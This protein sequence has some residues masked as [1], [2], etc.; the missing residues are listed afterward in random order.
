MDLTNDPIKIVSR[1]LFDDSCV[2]SLDPVRDNYMPIDPKLIRYGD[3]T[4]NG[5]QFDQVLSSVQKSIRRG[6]FGD[7]FQFGLEL[8]R[9]GDLYRKI[10]WNRLFV[11]SVEDIGP[12]NPLIVVELYAL[13]KIDT[14]LSLITAIYLFCKS[15]KSRLN[16]NAICAFFRD[17]EEYRNKEKLFIEAIQYKNIYK[18]F[19]VL[20]EVSGKDLLW[21]QVVSNM[22]TALL[23][24]L[25]STKSM[26]GSGGSKLV[27]AHIIHLH[28]MNM[29][30]T[31]E[32]YLVAINTKPIEDLQVFLT[33]F[34]SDNF[35]L[36][37]IPDYAIDKHTIEGKKRG[38]SYKHF[39]E[40]GAQ[41][42][43]ES[44]QLKPMSE[45]YFM[46]AK[47]YFYD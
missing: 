45:A 18:C 38:R 12:A 20:P 41:L 24:T 46:I 39:F 21:S 27:E 13:R 33:A 2:R 14:P 3:R 16:D 32:E 44:R 6:F 31:D 40:V 42:Y 23:K 35:N 11:I 1:R 26:K 25:W 29:I 4:F 47:Q 5:F 30:P 37:N 8:Y 34:M 28:C 15:E 22:Y 7:A 43:N 19:T 36:M 10:L 17:I 9:S